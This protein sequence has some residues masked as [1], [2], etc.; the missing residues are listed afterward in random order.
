MPASLLLCLTLRLCL[1][2]PL[3]QPQLIDGGSPSASGTRAAAQRS[4]VPS[5]M[6]RPAEAPGTWI[7]HL[8]EE[9]VHDSAPLYRTMLDTA[10][11]QQRVIVAVTGEAG[12][13]LFREIVG[14]P[15]QDSRVR[16]LHVGGGLSIWARDRY[17]FT[18]REGIDRTLVPR[19]YDLSPFRRYDAETGRVLSWTSWRQVKRLNLRLDG[20]NAL[21]TEGLV[22]VGAAVLN[23]NRDATPAEVEARLQLLF[24]RPVVLLGE[25]DLLPHDHL[26]M[27]L[28]LAGNGI[29]VLGSP[30]LGLAWLDARENA[31]ETD[32]VALAGLDISR[33]GTQ[34]QLTA[35]AFVRERLEE[36][37][38]E[39]VEVPALHDRSDG[40]LTW[41]NAVVDSA[42]REVWIPTYGVPE[43]DRLAEEAWR[44]TG[45]EPHAVDC[46]AL[47]RFGGALRCITNVLPHR[48][49][50][51]GPHVAPARGAR[52]RARWLEPVL[53]RR[54]IRPLLGR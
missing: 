4:V 16:F 50:S 15:V 7:W 13:R 49:S 21:V 27:F 40:L 17:I 9:F 53:R 2:T 5:A 37:G 12:E 41:T 25:P 48:S 11:A 26:D 51:P 33:E 38:Y 32:E 31:A 34:R 47:I 36:L 42:R 44:S 8:D 3:A 30:A 45:L 10:G 28:S 14:V 6:L 20:G 19:D 18:E 46:T 22:L 1:V 29:A 35:Y 54:R 24:E 43:L 39:V 23:E 52:A